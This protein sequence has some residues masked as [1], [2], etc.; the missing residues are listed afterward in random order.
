MKSP[1][2]WKCK[3]KLTLIVQLEFFLLEFEQVLF[4]LCTDGIERF[5][6]CCDFCHL[7]VHQG[8]DVGL[9][10]WGSKDKEKGAPVSLGYSPYLL[11]SHS[12]D[13]LAPPSR[14]S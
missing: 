8:L 11:G 9:S 5:N 12:A 14:A 3:W 4:Q 10:I 13:V 2:E 7:I 1:S 6:F